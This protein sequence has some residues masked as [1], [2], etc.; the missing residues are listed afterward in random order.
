MI[1]HAI[2]GVFAIVAVPGALAAQ[3][4]LTIEAA[5]T[6]VH[7]SPTVEARVVGQAH[8][9]RVLE[10]TREDG[11]W[12]TVVWPEATTRVGY[13]RLKVGV[14]DRTDGDDE[15]TVRDVQADVNA[16]ER[17]IW[18]IWDEQFPATTA[19]HSKPSR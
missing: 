10:V 9:G 19:L 7:E 14:L 12:L 17:A 4:T 5:S 2:A 6:D 8:H 3:T 15:P 1:R 18:A 16:V 11:D 13:V